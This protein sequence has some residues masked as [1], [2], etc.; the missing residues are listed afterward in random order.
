MVSVGMIV[1][2]LYVALCLGICIGFLLGSA[3]ELRNAA[4]VRNGASVAFMVN[5][6][7]G[8]NQAMREALQPGEKPWRG[9]SDCFGSGGKSRSCHHCK[10]TGKINK[11]TGEAW[12][13]PTNGIDAV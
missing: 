7:A 8:K 9:C 12:I 4:V 11:L 13:E 10:G 5:D 3:H 6:I 2:A 1:F